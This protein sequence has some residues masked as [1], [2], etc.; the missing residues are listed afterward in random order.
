VDERTGEPDF[1]EF[2][3]AVCSLL[4]A[5]ASNAVRKFGKKLLPKSAF[6]AYNKRGWG[7]GEDS[8]GRASSTA[9]CVPQFGRFAARRRRNLSI[10]LVRNP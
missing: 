9:A 10:L 6:I 3:V 7:G 1:A 2:A 5:N 8:S 4:V